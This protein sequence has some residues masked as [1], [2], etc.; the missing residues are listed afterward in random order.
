MVSLQEKFMQNDLAPPNLD[1]SPPPGEVEFSLLELP[2]RWQL[3]EGLLEYAGTAATI[4]WS[5]SSLAELLAAMHRIAGPERYGLILQA[6]GRKSEA[7]DWAFICSFATFLDGLRGINRVAVTA[8]WGRMLLDACEPDRRRAVMRVENSWESIAQR[9]I[10]VNWGTHYFGGKLAGWF[11]RHFGVNCWAV[12]TTFTA[13]GDLYDTFEISPSSITIETE[14]ERVEREEQERTG[15]L[16]QRTR[17]LNAAVERLAQAKVE[18]EGKSSII[19]RLSIPVVQLWDG[20]I[21]LSLVGDL[22]QDR[23]EHLVET[24]L[25]TVAQRGARILL[26]DVTGADVVDAAT[27]EVLLRTVRAV[28]LL[29]AETLLVGIRPVVARTLVELDVLLEGVATY[30]ELQQGLEAAFRKIGVVTSRV[31]KK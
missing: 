13:A 31:G 11:S 15:A 9:A 10:G 8:G 30:G 12:Q 23:A 6:Q 16:E 18:L 29:G 25:S 3:G 7:E 22:D 21:L 19:R 28:R 26:L 17:E 5:K 27:A 24:A 4:F 2:Y 20:I 14:L 1:I